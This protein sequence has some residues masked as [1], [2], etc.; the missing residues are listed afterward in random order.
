MEPTQKIVVLP[1]DIVLLIFNYILLITDKRQFVRTCQKFYEKL[2]KKSLSHYESNYFVKELANTTKCVER[3][4]IELYHD[5]YSNMIPKSYLNKNNSIIAQ[6]AGYFGDIE[7]LEKLKNNGHNLNGVYKFAAFNGKL[8]VLKWLKNNYQIYTCCCDCA[9]IFGHFN[10]ID[11]L[12]KELSLNC[13]KKGNYDV[14][15]WASETGCDW[16]RYTA[17]F[18]NNMQLFNDEKHDGDSDECMPELISITSHNENEDYGECIPDL[19]SETSHNENTEPNF[20]TK[21]EFPRKIITLYFEDIENENIYDCMPELIPNPSYNENEDIQNDN[22][23][24]EI[25]LA[26]LN[27]VFSYWEFEFLQLVRGKAEGWTWYSTK[28]TLII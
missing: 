17:T 1:F 9:Y 27:D 24:L 28:N 26:K 8:D 6:I 2:T 3:F 5:N 19:I 7:L 21:I 20:E 10:I 11:W 15:K 25:N 22:I 4:T 13:I 16:D 12:H 23:G 18:S 14:L